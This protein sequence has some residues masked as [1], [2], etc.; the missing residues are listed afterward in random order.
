[1]P[2][3]DD[4]KKHMHTQAEMANKSLFYSGPGGYAKKA[5]D[6]AKK[7]GRKLL[8]D[9]WVD[10]KYPDAWQNDI[11]ASKQFFD[12]ASAAMAQVSS[13]VVYVLLPSDTKGTNWNQDTVW[14]REEW[15]NL[16]GG[17]NPAVTKIVRVNPD[18]SNEETIYTK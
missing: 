7:T 16:R 10:S 14:A 13:G 17:K 8:K 12:I 2:S 11:D 15:P 4:V 3:I 18:N 5:N 6:L 9:F 1:M